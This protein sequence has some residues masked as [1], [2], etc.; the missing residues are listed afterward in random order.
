MT[1]HPRWLGA[2]LVLFGLLTPA[3]V[4]AQTPEADARFEQGVELLRQS[5]FEEAAEAFRQ[6][7]RLAPRVTTMCNLALTYDRW[8]DH[9]ELAVRAYRTCSRDDDTGRFGTFATRR[10]SELE[11]EIALTDVRTADPPADP[12]PAATEDHTLLWVG[13]AAGVGAAGAFTAGLVLALDS[14]ATV[15]DLHEQLGPAPAVVRGS[16]AHARLESARDAA[17]AATVLYVGAGVF[18]AAAAAF[19]TVDLV[20]AN[21]AEHTTV[22]LTPTGTGAYLSGAF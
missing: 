1:S 6:S 2:W 14:S 21:D 20:T 3:L 10:V 12:A 18:A 5:R 9:P 22:T 7:Y 8:G 19:I 16:P 15:D 13:V 11:R 4:A 17:T